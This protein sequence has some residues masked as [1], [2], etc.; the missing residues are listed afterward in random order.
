M[1]LLFA[2]LVGLTG[3]WFTRL[4]TGFLPTEDQGYAIVGIQLPDAASQERTREVVNQVES[5]L[6]ETEGVGNW[7]MIGGTSVLD[8]ANA[9]NAA[10]VYV[11]WT[12]VRRADQARAQ[13]GGHPGQASR[14]IPGDPGGDRLR[15]PAAGHPGP[16]RLG[17]VPAPARGPRRRGA[18]RELQQLT[19]EMIEAGN[20]QTSLQG[21]EHDLPGRRPPA[22]RR[23][24]P[25][26]GEEPGRTARRRL[27]HAPGGARVGLCQ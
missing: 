13:P 5:I 24:R 2:V 23:R 27:R 21:A 12:L 8:Q 20:A 15:L 9:S 4:P 10:L 25:G 18:R 3:W 17:R 14:Q 26:Q 22:L 6:K 7:V 11:R 19:D 16:G 1:M